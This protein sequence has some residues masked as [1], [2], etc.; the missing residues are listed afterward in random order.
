MLRLLDL[1][2]SITGL[3]LGAPLLLGGFKSEVQRRIG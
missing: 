2:F 3:F 1:L